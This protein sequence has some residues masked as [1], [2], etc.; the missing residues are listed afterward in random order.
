MGATTRQS[1]TPTLVTKR[2]A[3][4]EGKVAPSDMAS[5]PAMRN[6][7]ASTSV[8]RRPARSALQPAVRMEASM[9]TFMDP[10]STSTCSSVRPRSSRMNSS[11]PLISARSGG[12][13]HVKRCRAREQL[14]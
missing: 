4:R 10:D 14:R 5:A 11:A 2:A 7:L 13:H 3:M 1:P 8:A 12:T 9:N 6:A